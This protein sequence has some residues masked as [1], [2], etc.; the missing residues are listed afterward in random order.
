MK[1][2]RFFTLC[3][4]LI[5]MI[6]PSV[7]VFGTNNT[8]SIQ[9]TNTRIYKNGNYEYKLTKT[10]KAVITKYL[11]SDTTVKTPSKLGGHIVRKITQLA[12]TGT[13]VK[14]LIV[15]DTVTKIAFN[16]FDRS[17]I[18]SLTLGKSVKILNDY[19]TSRLRSPLINMYDLTEIKVKKDNKYFT[20]RSG[21]L[22]NKKLTKLIVYP[23]AKS[24]NEF[25]IPKSVK[26]IART[27]FYFN[28]K[29]KKVKLNKVQ[30]IRTYAFYGCKKLS[31]IA[32]PK[33]VTKIEESAF[34]ACKKV[35]KLKINANSKLK[36]YYGAFRALKIKTL[37]VPNVVGD[38]VFADCKKLQKITIPS[39]V[40]SLC[41]NEFFNCKKLKTVTIPSSVKKI[42]NFSIGFRGKV[43]NP[44]KIL[45]FTISGKKG[46]PAEAYAKRSGISFAAV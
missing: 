14:K 9:A 25:K 33:S 15:G 21:V 10:G 23:A 37:K 3:A 27:A 30:E 28:Q 16:A 17:S 43:G 2:L 24:G 39:N 6:I 31:K 18:K 26:V 7:N 12:F 32:I 11:G 29:L 35:T 4:I 42:E 5:V 22:Y 20:G 44:K 46:S 1:N 45:G 34:A 13:R 36:I 8:F 19:T 41:R 38:S 40:K